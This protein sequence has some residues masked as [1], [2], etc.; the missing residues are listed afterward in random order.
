[1]DNDLL[2]LLHFVNEVSMALENR[3][4]LSNYLDWFSSVLAGKLLALLP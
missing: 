2:P 1:M 4:L 3:K